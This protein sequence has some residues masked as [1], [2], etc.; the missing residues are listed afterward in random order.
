VERAHLMANNGCFYCRKINAG[1][2]SMECPERL[3]IE[4]RRAAVKAT[5]N[6]VAEQL[7]ED[8]KSEESENE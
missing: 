6:K 8:E 1:H 2:M 3:A 5:V 4:A 7:V